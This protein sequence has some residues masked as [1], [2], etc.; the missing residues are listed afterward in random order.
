[1]HEELDSA[2]GFAAALARY[3][4]LDAREGPLIAAE[5]RSVLLEHGRTTPDAYVLLHGLTTTPA[6]FSEFARMLHASGANVL[7]PR[8]PRHG[9][10]DRLTHELA[11]LT[12]AELTATAREIVEATRGLGER[13]TVVGFSAGGTLATW[14][15]QHLRV[16]RV[17]AIAPLLGVA[18]VPSALG[19][20]VT[21]AAL[22]APN[23]FL[24]WNPVERE[25]HAPTHGYPR[26]ATHAVAR[27]WRLGLDVLERARRHPPA[28]HD[29]VLVSNASETTVNNRAIARLAGAWRAHA[30]R[31]IM[32][33]R[34]RGLPPS[35]DIVEPRRRRPLA[36]SVYPAL[37]E[38]ITGGG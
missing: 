18:W 23:L 6:Q 38:I 36:A 7:V 31:R 8:L 15:A 20:T 4:R 27:V 17:V 10:A 22:R 28:T 25:R 19:H 30:D 2:A 12:A 1:M 5:G 21:R 37:F 16:D 24:W 34:L 9:H 11:G 32:V 14:I 13:V 29:V 35:H 26:Y 33:H 3:Q